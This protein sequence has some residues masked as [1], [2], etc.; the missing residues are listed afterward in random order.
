MMHR[1]ISAF[2]SAVLVLLL[3][4]LGSHVSNALTQGSLMPTAGCGTNFTGSGGMD[5]GGNF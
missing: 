3:A 1:R 5:R 2:T 4:A